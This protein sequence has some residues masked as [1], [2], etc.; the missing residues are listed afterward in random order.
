MPSRARPE[1][2]QTP[3]DPDFVSPKREP[4]RMAD[5]EVYEEAMRI[6]ADDL[7][8]PEERQADIESLPTDEERMEFKRS[9]LRRAYGMSG[10]HAKLADLRANFGFIGKTGEN[11]GVGGGYKFVE[12]TEISRRF[13]AE[14]SKRNL[15]MVPVDMRLEEPRPSSSGKQTVYTLASMWRITDADS[16]EYIE[17]PAYGQG[18]DQADKALPKAQTN[19]MK[20]A[21]LLLLQAAGD[22]PE[23]DPRTDNIE[24]TDQLPGVHISGSSIEG[25]RQGGRQ[26]EVTRPQLDQIR[27]HAKRLDLSPEALATLIGSTLGGKTVEVDQEAPL[28]EQQRTVLDFIEGLSF[29]EAGEVIQQLEGTLDAYEA[30]IAPEDVGAK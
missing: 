2:V 22:D 3:D 12:A 6:F 8:D 17:V 27:S 23:N 16:G 14:A 5:D 30:A 13:V 25:V 20:Y 24:N 28:H 29:P 18:A 4:E 11:K 21:I 19:A 1:P 15:T 7:V 10:L 26:S 9:E